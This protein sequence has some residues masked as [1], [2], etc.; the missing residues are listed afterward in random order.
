MMFAVAV[1][2]IGLQVAT[3]VQQKEAWQHY[4]PAYS[5]LFLAAA[6]IAASFV[7]W[8]LSPSP[9]GRQDV[10]EVFDPEF[11]VLLIDV[12]L[13]VCYF[14]LV[15]SVDFQ[16]PE[17]GDKITYTP[18][19]VPE[20]RW[21]FWIFCIYLLWDV[22]T[23]IAVYVVRRFLQGI[24]DDDNWFPT[25]AVRFVPTVVCLFLAYRLWRGVSDKL[26]PSEVVAADAAL[27]AVVLLFRALKDLCSAIFPRKGRAFSTGKLIVSGVCTVFFFVAFFIC[28][29]DALSGAPEWLRAFIIS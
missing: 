25:V 3:L 28:K 7:G 14:I 24:K 20:S 29:H 9:G 6:V 16:K 13:V 22:W 4:L 18:S 1:G 19:A 11:V 10:T 5:H 26:G 8:T 27:L 15:R 17:T 12:A 21:I 23:K 2:E